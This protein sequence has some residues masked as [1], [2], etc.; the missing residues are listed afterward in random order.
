LSDYGEYYWCCLWIGLTSD[1]IILNCTYMYRINKL[2]K[3]K[4]TLFHTQDL[5]VLWGITNRNTLYTTIKRYVEK[6]I[7]APIYKG[8]YTTVDLDQLDPVSLGIRALHGYAYLST[9]TV[10]GRAGVIFQL[11]SQITLVSSLSKIISI[12]DQSYRVRSMRDEFLYNNLEIS[13]ENGIPIAS[14]ERAMADLLYFNPHYYFDN[15]KAL[16]IKKVRSI[17]KEVG[18]L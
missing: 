13:M 2:L 11:S 7:F 3:E 16:D 18:Y 5:A 8:F 4:N 9:E 12:G 14:P 17:Q 10:L 1:I 6:G 15:W